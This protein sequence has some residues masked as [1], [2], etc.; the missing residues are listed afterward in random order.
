MEKENKKIN[1][2][3]AEEIYH[4]LIKNSN[5]NE[6]NN[7]NNDMIPKKIIL[8]Q[9]GEDNRSFILTKRQYNA[10]IKTMLYFKE[11]YFYIYLSE[12][13][14]KNEFIL[15]EKDSLTLININDSYKNYES[16]EIIFE[17][18]IY[19]SQ[20]NWAIILTMDN[21]GVLAATEEFM[22]EYKKNYPEWKNDIEQ[23]KDYFDSPEFNL[24]AVEKT[25]NYVTENEEGLTVED[26]SLPWKK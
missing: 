13:Y 21:Y 26:R 12:W 9:V 15:S 19:S 23:F 5:F 24:D 6:D 18:V 8:A 4:L 16:L 22:N 14:K 11:D 25:F 3:E 17:N 1:L 2:L 7:F 20:K 10:L